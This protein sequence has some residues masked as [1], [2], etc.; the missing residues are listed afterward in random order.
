MP[1]NLVHDA[2]DDEDSQMTALDQ[3]HGHDHGPSSHP[4]A[5]GKLQEEIQTYEKRIQGL[6]EGVGMLKE[7]VN[8]SIAKCIASRE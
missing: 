1:A 6:V 7:R 5:N 8:R 4:D 3:E 2:V